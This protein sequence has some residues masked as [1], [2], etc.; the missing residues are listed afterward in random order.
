MK[1]SI[2]PTSNI[3][4]GHGVW[5]LS[6]LTWAA[7]TGAFALVCAFSFESLKYM[8]DLWSKEEY[9]YAY[10]IPAVSLFMVWQKRDTLQRMSFNGSWLGTALVV[11]GLALSLL[12]E[13]ST[14][15]VIV[16][17]AVL[18]VIAGLALAFM[19]RHGVRQIWAP[20]LLLAFM[21][22]LPDFLYRGVS[23]ASQLVS[24]QL[25]VGLIRLSGISVLLEGNVIDLGSYKLQVAEACNGLR[26]LFPLTALGFIAACVFNGSPWKRAVI[27]LSAIPITILMNSFRIGVIGLTV[28]RWGR[29]AAEGFLH[30]FEGWVVFMACVAVLVGEMW[31][32][33]RLGSR[34]RFHEV[35]S[36]DLPERPLR[37]TP[38]AYRRLPLPFIAALSI[39]IAMM[40]VFAAL[41]ARVEPPLQR[42]DFTQ[43]PMTLGEW[44]GVPEKMNPVYLDVLKLDDYLLADFTSPDKRGI[45]LYVAYYASQRKGESAHS[46]RS[47]IPGGGWEIVDLQQRTIPGSQSSGKP[48]SVNRVLIEKGEDKQL[49]YYWFQQ[50]GRVITNEYLVKWYLFWDA[51]TRNRTDGA[52]VRLVANVDS[53]RRIDDVDRTLSDFATIVGARLPAYVPD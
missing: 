7:I 31:L 11:V 13:L 43:F 45:N 10:F 49:V 18:V 3:G 41:P 52:L 28:D 25:G 32:L 16:Q 8:V 22:P 12:G 27:F 1:R 34:R 20:L 44:H 47:C 42:R 53:A 14:L 36:L 50:R 35:F 30:Q 21:I 33:A 24:S 48:I 40:V 19:G 39:L 37:G 4:S 9:G 46:P 51:I 6:P 17:Y 29:M 38:F 23:A 26:Y 2:E 5:R 15:F